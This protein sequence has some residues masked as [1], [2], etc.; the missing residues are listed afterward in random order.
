[1]IK[2]ISLWHQSCSQ[3]LTLLV[4]PW[5]Q[6]ALEDMAENEPWKL[7]FEELTYQRTKKAR[8][9]SNLEA[10]LY[11]MR[12]APFYSGLATEQK[13]A[14]VLY[15]AIKNHCLRNGHTYVTQQNIE[16]LVGS[17][18]ENATEAVHFLLEREVLCRDVSPLNLERFHL[19]RYWRAEETIV[20]SFEKLM[21][22]G[23]GW[24]VGIDF[25]RYCCVFCYLARRLFA[26]NI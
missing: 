5:L 19:M 11:L 25:Q 3:S 10:P 20:S 8:A 17:E 12:R 7:G 14:L 2:V 4:I 13:A 21:A 1:M 6:D 22:L 16:Y 9:V 26:M 18:L 24:N 23:A 15:D